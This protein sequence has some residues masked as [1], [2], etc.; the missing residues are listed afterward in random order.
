MVVRKVLLKILKRRDD[1]NSQ[2]HDRSN[3]KARITSTKT[4]NS[5]Q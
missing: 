5:R 3:V 2:A 1:F 4:V